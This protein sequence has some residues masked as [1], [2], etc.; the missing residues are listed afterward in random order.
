M[1]FLLNNVSKANLNRFSKKNLFFPRN[2]VIWIL[3]KIRVVFQKDPNT[4]KYII[5]YVY[6][7]F[8][9]VLLWLRK[10]VL[11][12]SFCHPTVTLIKETLLT[13]FP[14]I[15][16]GVSLDILVCIGFPSIPL[17]FFTKE[18][19][20]FWIAQICRFRMGGVYP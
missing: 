13:D 6:F 9:K 18:L 19:I 4:K 11:D 14:D 8:C 12:F 15:E 5:I 2:I 20:K 16:G 3:E 7:F 1:F 10:E 17:S